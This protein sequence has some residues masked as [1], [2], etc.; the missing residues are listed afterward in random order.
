MYVSQY[1]KIAKEIKFKKFKIS[2]IKK[3][4]PF[5]S[6]YLLCTSDKYLFEIINSR[7][8][9]ERYKDYYLLG[10]SKDKE[11]LIKYITQLVDMLYNKKSIDLSMLKQEKQKGRGGL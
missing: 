7:E 5:R 3:D 2:N 11:E 4:S 1:I 6:C 10:I 8:L 9:S